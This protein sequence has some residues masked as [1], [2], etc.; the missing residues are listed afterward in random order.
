[1]GRDKKVVIERE[2]IKDLTSKKKLS[3]QIKEEFG[4]E[5]RIRNTKKEKIVIRLEDQI[6]I[7]KNSKIEVELLEATGAKADPI[8]GKLVWKLEV[9]PSETKK[10]ILRYSIRYPKDMQVSY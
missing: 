5:I 4:Y 9:N 7:S 1:L 10:V 2:Q 8:T 3:S 6:P